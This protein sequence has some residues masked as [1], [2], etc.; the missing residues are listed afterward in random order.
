MSPDD[1]ARPDDVELVRR[2]KAGEEEAFSEL[3]ERHQARVYQHAERLLGNRQDAEEVLQDTFLQAYRN[4]AG[5]EERSRFST[6]IYRI[7]TNEALMRL[8]RASRRREVLLEEAPS[9]EVERASDEVREF[10]RSALDDV[11][12]REVRE[13]LKKALVE[14]PDEYRVVF[15]LRDVEGFSNAEVAD[16]LGLSVPAVKSRLHRSR[17]WLRDRLARIFGEQR[18]AGLPEEST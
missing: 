13:I 11:M 16:I 1:H 2:A 5:F 14:L 15:V 8:R 17:I 10:A 6:W 12:D 9:G 18:R 3:V 7:A 4:L